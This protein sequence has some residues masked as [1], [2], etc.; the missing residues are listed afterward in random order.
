MAPA[1]TASASLPPLSAL[2]NPDSRPQRPRNSAS[3]GSSSPGSPR[4]PLDVD[5]SFEFDVKSQHSQRR[6]PPP[7]LALDRPD[8]RPSMERRSISSLLNG[9]SSRQSPTEKDHP[10]TGATPASHPLPITPHHEY[11][12][13]PPHYH[14]HSHSGEMRSG[15]YPPPAPRDH[16]PITA[17]IAP[18]PPGYYKGGLDRR[19]S[20]QPGPPPSDYFSPPQHSPPGPPTHTGVPPGRQLYL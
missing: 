11:P 10:S 4:T 16:R 3:T 9:G 12:A 5:M 6:Q 7:P 2:L 14:A 13:P 19:H 1:A 8:G 18:P 17:P 15:F 20:Y